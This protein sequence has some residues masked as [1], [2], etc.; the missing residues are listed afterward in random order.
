MGSSSVGSLVLMSVVSFVRWSSWSWSMWSVVLRMLMLLLCCVWFHKVSI[1]GVMMGPFHGRW[2]FCRYVGRVLVCMWCVMSECFC[3]VVVIWSSVF[4]RSC[5]VLS[6]SGCCGWF[7]VM[8]RLV[9]CR[10]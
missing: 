9:L 2:W 6:M 10:W 1:S 7:A 4:T 3:L 8:L 5:M